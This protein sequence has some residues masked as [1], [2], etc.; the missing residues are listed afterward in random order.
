MSSIRKWMYFFSCAIAVIAG[1]I[2]LWGCSLSKYPLLALWAVVGLFLA[3]G[4]V[5]ILYDRKVTQEMIRVFG[6]EKF[7]AMEA[8][9]TYWVMG[10]IL[11]ISFFIA[12]AVI[13][14]KHGVL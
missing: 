4:I 13:I 5:G 6:E 9:A 2:L 10:I 12:I 1:C 11:T 3:G 7:Y 8:F 14:L